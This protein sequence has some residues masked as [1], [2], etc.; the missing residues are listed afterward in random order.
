MTRRKSIL[1]INTN[2]VWGGGEKWHYDMASLLYKR[3]YSVN[4]FAHCDGDLI[5]R[6]SEANI[7]VSGI[8]INKLSFLDPLALVLLK[9]RIVRIRPDVV[10]LNLPSDMKAAGL[11]AKLAGVENILYRRGTALPVNP[12]P[13]NRWFFRNVLSGVIVN[14]RKTRELINERCKL[15]DDDKIHVVYNGIDEIPQEEEIQPI[16]PGKLIIGN[17][18][19]LEHQK[20]QYR[21]IELALSLKEEGLDFEIRI[22]GSGPLHEQLQKEI[23]QNGL[24]NE[25]KLLGFM[26]DMSVFYSSI[27]VFVLPSSWE[28]FGYVMA[29]AM[30]H[31]RP[32]IAFDVSS[33]PE[34]VSHDENGYLVPFGDIN[35][36]KEQLIT[37]AG[38]RDLLD[39][40]GRNARR[41]VLEKFTLERAAAQIENI[42]NL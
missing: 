36:L 31:R 42:I 40:L 26:D 8:K 35:Q 30:A 10:I 20:G 7:P 33:N 15:I 18:G 23:I 14:S 27:S 37:L 13:V 24:Q 25:V 19:R 28:G 29:E 16:L 34:I 5:K 39:E 41:M 17:A 22:A 32:V 11:A 4:V 21:L 12:H 1:F 6:C 3:N 2:K 9:K 38:N